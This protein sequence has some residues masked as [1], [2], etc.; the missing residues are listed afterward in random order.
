MAVYYATKAFVLSFSEAVAEEV[1]GTG[2]TVTALCP[3]PTDT[4]FGEAAQMR[5]SRL[6]RLGR[7][8]A[9]EVAR[10]GQRAFRQGRVVVVPGLRN[11]LLAFSIRLS[12]RSIARRIAGGLNKST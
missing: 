7:M 1:A 3:G 8:S 6:F 11:R 5:D 10:I 9:Q 2:V 4:G 12:P